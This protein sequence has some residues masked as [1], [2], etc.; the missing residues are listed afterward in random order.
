MPLARTA[1]I[2][3]LRPGTA[4]RLG[5]PFA[6]L[7][8]AL[9]GGP[10]L[11]QT[12]NAAAA[13]A[14]QAEYNRRIAECDTGQPRP[15]YNACIRAAGAALDRTGTMSK[16]GMSSESAD[17]RSTILQPPGATMPNYA[18]SAVMPET[19]TSPDGRS[20]ILVP[21]DSTMRGGATR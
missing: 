13:A 9:A 21:S 19:T 1:P 17:G 15:A 8:L 12:G 11:A 5:M 3:S 10:A 7:V 14:A 2:R 16:G 6:A 18:P 4:A 20:T